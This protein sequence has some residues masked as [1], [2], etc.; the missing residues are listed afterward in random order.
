[1]KNPKLGM[2]VSWS[3]PDAGEC[4]GA[5]TISKINGDVISLTMDDGGEVQAE[6]CELSVLN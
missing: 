5:G 4:S 1:M 3:D 6:C 2:R